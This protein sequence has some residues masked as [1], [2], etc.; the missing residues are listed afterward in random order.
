MTEKVLHNFVFDEKCNFDFSVL[1]YSFELEFE[2]SQEFPWITDC[3]SVNKSFNE[4]S[5][6]Q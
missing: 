6:T 1:S 3:F 5:G 4:N 2:S